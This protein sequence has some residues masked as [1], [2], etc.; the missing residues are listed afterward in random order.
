[1]V[2]VRR[3]LFL[4]HPSTYP[5]PNREV[6]GSNWAAANGWA[7]LNYGVETFACR[8]RQHTVVPG[9]PSGSP[10]AVFKRRSGKASHPY[11]DSRVS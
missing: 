11:M 9:G 6:R 7:V 2:C 4:G 10:N 5:H 8:P 1:M 3:P